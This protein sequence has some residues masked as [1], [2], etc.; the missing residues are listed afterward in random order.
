MCGARCFKSILSSFS[1]KTSS[2]FEQ[3]QQMTPEWQL[4]TKVDYKMPQKPFFSHFFFFRA[5]WL[6]RVFTSWWHLWAS[7][8]RGVTRVCPQDNFAFVYWTLGYVFV[9]LCIC[10]CD[11]YE[12]R[13]LLEEWHVS[14][15]CPHDKFAFVYW[16]ICVF[17]LLRYLYVPLTFLFSC[18]PL[19]KIPNSAKIK[20][21]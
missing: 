4:S 10:I 2:T 6:S 15:V 3:L 7:P 13:P 8:T 18:E 17:V 14:V 9:T 5:G 21:P 16:T 1:I 12:S 20:S 11:T 19:S